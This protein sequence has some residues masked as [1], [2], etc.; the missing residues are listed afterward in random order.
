MTYNPDTAQG[1]SAT[2][3]ADSGALTLAD[4]DV[5]NRAGVDYKTTMTQRVALF[6][7]T[8]AGSRTVSFPAVL[9]G[10]DH[11]KNLVLT[12]TSGSLGVDGT[13]AD[14]FRCH[15]INT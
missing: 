8:P 15:V 7:K 3:L 2:A 4:L 10:S 13:V 11:D 6:R 9:T 14:G 12:G 5:I 1:I